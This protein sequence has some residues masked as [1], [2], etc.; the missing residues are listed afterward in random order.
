[1]TKKFSEVL[2]TGSQSD[3]S[4]W[5]KENIGKRLSSITKPELRK[6]IDEL[7]APLYVDATFAHVDQAPNVLVKFPP[8]S[9]KCLLL[10]PEHFC[11][12]PNGKTLSDGIQLIAV[13]AHYRRTLTLENGIQLYR[14]FYS[15]N[16]QFLGETVVADVTIQIKNDLM[17]R[18]KT[19]VLNYENIRPKS[20]CRATF[21][22]KIGT[23][24]GQIPIPGSQKFIEFKKL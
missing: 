11:L 22:M 8:V 6:L 17:S 4:S 24:A 7:E 13:P 10:C 9:D 2:E 19:L 21:G 18:K 16:A 15:T 23:D 14:N 1:M 5:I 12:I 20:T 3:L